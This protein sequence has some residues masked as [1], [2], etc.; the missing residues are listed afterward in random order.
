MSGPLRS[1]AQAAATHAHD[2][3]ASASI[4]RRAAA[5][6]LDALIVAVFAWLLDLTYLRLGWAWP[7]EAWPWHLR[8]LATISAPAWL[9]GALFEAAPGA[10]T[11]GKRALGLRVVDTYGGRVTAAR[12]CA[13][14]LLKLAPLLVAQAALAYPIPVTVS[15][16]AP[17]PRLL[18]GAY[19]LGG[20]YVGVAMMSLKKQ[21]VHDWATSA[22]VV[23]RPL[24]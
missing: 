22:C 6:F 10:A 20:L 18:V 16:T 12:A 11:L 17:L 21:S 13:R 19:A 8:A 4:P 15:G 1:A 14:A 3:R 24:T 7:V 5:F 9:Y 23:R 2:P